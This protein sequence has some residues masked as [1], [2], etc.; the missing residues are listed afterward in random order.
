MMDERFGPAAL[1]LAGVTA[2]VLGW[3]P[4]DFWAATPADVAA[5]LAG[6]R[7]EEEAGGVDRAGLAMMMEQ[8]PDG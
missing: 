2:R 1:A 8:C 3:R 6:W 4:D 7:A 5:V